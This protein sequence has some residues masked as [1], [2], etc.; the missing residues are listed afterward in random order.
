MII[1][2]FNSG[3]S[4]SSGP[5]NYLLGPKTSD[6]RVREPKPELFMGDVEATSNGIDSNKRNLKYT[7]G[8]I[9]FRDS[10]KPTDDQLKDICNDFLKAMAPGLKPTADYNYYMVKHQHEGNTEVHFII[11]RRE[12]N[13]N[14]SFNICPPGKK[15]QQYIRDF[16]SLIN[17]KYGYDQ[18]VENKLKGEASIDKF[19]NLDKNETLKSKTNRL[20]L[21]LEKL[22]KAGEIK[23]R[24]ELIGKLEKHGAIITR[25]GNDYISLKF[26]NKDIYPKAV[27]LKN[28][29]FRADTDYKKLLADSIKPQEKTLPEEKFNLINDRF[30]KVMEEKRLFNE[31]QFST[32]VSR[33][34]YS[35]KPK[36]RVK[37]Y[38]PR[39]AKIESSF[40]KHKS[41]KF[42][43]FSK[44][45][46]TLGLVVKDTPLIFEY[47][48]SKPIPVDSGGSVG[49]QTVHQVDKEKVSNLTSTTNS[50]PKQGS[51]ETSGPT[52][53]SG[54]IVA[55][56]NSIA[57]IDGQ[58]MSL[59]QQ[60]TYAKNPQQKA[61]LMSK[62]VSL[63]IE[64]ERLEA[65][66][67][68]EKQRALNQPKPKP[69]WA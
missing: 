47:G 57:E 68:E 54:G 30:K 22:V 12:K 16:Q 8:V 34:E 33:H 11:E 14:K 42:M 66:L 25:K 36:A 58:I 51:P 62:A 40:L 17:H 28:P 32:K 37:N 18:V 49:G 61:M 15:T 64:R 7:S 10:E 46:K 67:A 65:K 24:D 52:H 2:L 39:A 31:K 38:V 23:N 59:V 44:F 45:G 19:F 55:L 35:F 29:I 56:G 20:V 4:K 60:A 27:R 26:P 13:T 1:Q 3:T 21:V 48:L 5:R 63:R 6:G 69:K 50:S 9:A 43:K 41:L 53:L